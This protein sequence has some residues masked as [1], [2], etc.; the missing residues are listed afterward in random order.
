MRNR[1]LGITLASILT[2]IAMT[3]Y[4]VLF[5]LM[6]IN[7]STVFTYLHTL[8]PG[9]SGPEKIHLAM[10]RF[11]AAY[12]AAMALL[13]ALIGCGLWKLWNWIRLVILVMTGVSLV[14]ALP[15]IPL[16]AHS[17]SA[18]AWALWAVRIVLC[19][20]WG[21]YLMRSSVREAFHRPVAAPRQT[22]A[23]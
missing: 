8:S 18:G 2:F 17:G 10:G 19:V 21:W 6:L 20:L 15:T 14:G 11:E 1:P 12:Y 23:A 7:S 4:V 22:Q 16:L 13:T 3:Q 9:G 5:A